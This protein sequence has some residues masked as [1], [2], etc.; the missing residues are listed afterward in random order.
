MD[1]GLTAIGLAQRAKNLAMVEVLSIKESP[2][3]PSRLSRHRRSLSMPPS[4]HDLMSLGIIVNDE[5]GRDDSTMSKADETSA[6]EMKRL[7]EDEDSL[8]VTDVSLIT[9]EGSSSGA[10]SQSPSSDT[11]PTPLLDSI[12]A[13][14]DDGSRDEVQKNGEDAH[15]TRPWSYSSSQISVPA[16]G[17]ADVQSKSTPGSAREDGSNDEERKPILLMAKRAREKKSVRVESPTRTLVRNSSARS[18]AI[19]PSS[20]FSVIS[21]SFVSTPNFLPSLPDDTP[22]YT[23]TPLPATGVKGSVVS[24]A[25]KGDGGVKKSGQKYARLMKSSSLWAKYFGCKLIIPGIV[26]SSLRY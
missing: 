20:S 8:T 25:K 23:S 9:P 14:N 19:Y 16:L 2:V 17:E 15:R 10:T 1:A 7:A 6:Q 21:S 18:S 4:Q 3:T 26:S 12:P 5:S 24:V 13:S 22:L 11:C